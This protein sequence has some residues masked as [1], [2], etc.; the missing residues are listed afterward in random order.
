MRL[1]ELGLRF[2]MK[3]SYTHI[4]YRPRVYEWF[5][6]VLSL[7]KFRTVSL[8][9]VY[10]EFSTVPPMIYL[11]ILSYIHPP[12]GPPV[13]RFQ[14]FL[15]YFLLFLL[16]PRGK[17]NSKFMVMKFK[18]HNSR[19]IKNLSRAK[20][21]LCTIYSFFNERRLLLA[22]VISVSFESLTNYERVVTVQ[23]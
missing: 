9:A 16:L 6:F 3:S 8:Y 20:T 10:W 2:L 4:H 22:I 21:S 11:H 15:F 18:N 14:N 17:P 12:R 1:T 5:C 7:S 13:S 19:M 23:V